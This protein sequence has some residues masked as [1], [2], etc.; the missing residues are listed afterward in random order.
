MTDSA[1]P[2]TDQ[3]WLD[4]LERSGLDLSL[5]A[6]CSK[7]VICL[8]D[9]LSNWCEACAMA[10]QRRADGWHERNEEACRKDA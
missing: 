10:E 9:G 1:P 7:L 5:C 8:P 2:R 3:D 4:A 6:N